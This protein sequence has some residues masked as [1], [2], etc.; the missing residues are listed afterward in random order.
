M[1]FALSF[2]WS[3]DKMRLINASQRGDERRKRKKNLVLCD[4]YTGISFRARSFTRELSVVVD[5]DRGAPGNGGDG[6]AFGI[7]IM[8]FIFIFL[9]VV[10]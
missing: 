7:V 2:S 4:F 5:E 6:M 3:L 8:F 10:Y 9:R 1:S